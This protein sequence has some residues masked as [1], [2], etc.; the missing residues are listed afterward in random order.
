MPYTQPTPVSSYPSTGNH[1]LWDLFY[2][3]TGI[4]LWAKTSDISYIFVVFVY[5]TFYEVIKQ[6]VGTLAG[7]PNFSVIANVLQ[8]DPQ[9]TSGTGLK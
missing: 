7:L 5:R 8:C 4:P 3:Y 1:L 9:F 2:G 6:T